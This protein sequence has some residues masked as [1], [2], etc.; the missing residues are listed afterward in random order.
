MP[1]PVFI[2]YS[3]RDADFVNKLESAMKKAGIETWVDSDRF[4]GG[5]EWMASLAGGLE[6]SAA[7]V[8]VISPDAVKSKWVY[9][10]ISYA[11]RRGIQVIPIV[12]RD[13]QIP[14]RLDYPI[15][16][17]QRIDFTG[18]SFV[19]GMNALIKAIG[20]VKQDELSQS[21]RLENPESDF[22]IHVEDVVEFLQRIPV[23]MVLRFC[24]LNG[25][26]YKEII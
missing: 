14:P 5:E 9:K 10:E 20:S 26:T 21:G 19:K 6:N 16:G 18:R 3:K 24:R 1:K 23:R 22:T 7:V 15:G 2:S 11:V 12:C 4:T 25:L 13:A 17:V 8:L